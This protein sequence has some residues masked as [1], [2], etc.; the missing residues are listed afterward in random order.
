MFLKIF[1]LRRLRESELKKYKVV[2]ECGD[3]TWWGI[4]IEIP[5]FAAVLN[6]VFDDGKSI[7]WDNNNGNDYTISVTNPLTHDQLI[8]NKKQQL[9]KELEEE[10]NSRVNGAA[11]AARS[12]IISRVRH[13]LQTCIA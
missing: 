4:N 6:Y 8:E 3:G 11:S 5:E 1:S 13:N 2:D 12:R 10:L 7:V 9:R